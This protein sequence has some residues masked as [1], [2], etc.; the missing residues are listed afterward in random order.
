MSFHSNSCSFCS[1]ALDEEATRQEKKC[2][3]QSDKRYQ[4]GQREGEENIFAHIREEEAKLMFLYV[5]TLY[6]Y[7]C[8]H[9]LEQEI[10]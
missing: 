2:K 6:V 8:I 9:K 7:H 5:L 1:S 4:E 3:R 10:Y